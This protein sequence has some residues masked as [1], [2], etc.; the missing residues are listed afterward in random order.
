MIQE[1]RVACVSMVKRNLEKLSL[2]TTVRSPT[3]SWVSA[4]KAL[5]LIN[6]I[7]YFSFSKDNI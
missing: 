4:R 6:G 5:I 3:D 1:N 7:A 2:K